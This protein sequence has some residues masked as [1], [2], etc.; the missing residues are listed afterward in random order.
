MDANHQGV[1]E[2]FDSFSS[3]SSSSSP[4]QVGRRLSSTG[5]N[6]RTRR[7]P[8]RKLPAPASLPAALAFFLLALSPPRAHGFSTDASSLARSVTRTVALTNSGVVIIANFT[9]GTSLPLRGFY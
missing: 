3:S 4:C 6:Q 7:P 5:S 8:P 1:F 9:N 2:E